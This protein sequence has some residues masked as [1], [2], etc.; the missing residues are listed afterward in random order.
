[1][2]PVKFSPDSTIE[3]DPWAEAYR[4]RFSL[5]QNSKNLHAGSNPSERILIIRGIV[6]A[7]IALALVWRRGACQ[8]GRKIAETTNKLKTDAE[9][10][11]RMKCLQ[12][13]PI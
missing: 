13:R 6:P 8:K 5:S 3:S 1:M 7:S 4:R 12:P 2:I 10:A 11:G 9:C